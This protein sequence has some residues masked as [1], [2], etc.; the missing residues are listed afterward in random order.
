MKY[1]PVPWRSL[2]PDLIASEMMPAD[3]RLYAAEN[4]FVM[5]LNSEL[6]TYLPLPN[7]RRG[8]CLRNRHVPDGFHCRQGLQGLHRYECIDAIAE[9]RTHL[10]A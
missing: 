3:E 9:F 6:G 1:K 4:P 5:T 2:V 8:D 7:E 10:A